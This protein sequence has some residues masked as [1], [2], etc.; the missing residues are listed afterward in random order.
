MK[1]LI[2]FLTFIFSIAFLSNCS[3]DDSRL[4]KQIPPICL[5]CYD[6]VT[7]EGY[8]RWKFLENRPYFSEGE[9]SY[10]A[11]HIYSSM[12]YLDS[13]GW[14]PIYLPRH[15]NS[16][17]Y[18]SPDTGIVLIWNW[19]LFHAVELRKN[20]KG[21]TKEGIYMGDNMSKFFLTYPTFT[22]VKEDSSY[23]NKDYP[24]IKYLFWFE[25]SENYFSAGFSE[26]RKL[27][28]LYIYKKEGLE[29][30]I[31]PYPDN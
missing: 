18:S 15:I 8:G 26:N 17:E 16:I 5:T 28:Y 10:Y 3:K 13:C 6:T 12:D 20:W 24:S 22:P 23:T 25:T 19:Y 31:L 7:W 4:I 11:N 9:E 21:C 29:V 30:R 14:I 2:S 1:T 27:N